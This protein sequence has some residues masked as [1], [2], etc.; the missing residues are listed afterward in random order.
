[1]REHT[2]H[3]IDL[4]TEQIHDLFDVWV[5]RDKS[6]DSSARYGLLVTKLAVHEWIANLVQHAAFN[7]QPPLIRLLVTPRPFGFHCLVE[8]NSDGF[9]FEAEVAKQSRMLNNP[10]PSERGRGLLMMLACTEDFVYETSPDGLQHVEFVVHPP[11]DTDEMPTLFPATD[12][13][14]G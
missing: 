8:D 10:E 3:D 14:I 13:S 9:D 11:V 2:F 7:V 1:M 4:V 6:K 5:Q 12:Q